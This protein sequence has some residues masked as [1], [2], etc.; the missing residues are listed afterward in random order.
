MTNSVWLHTIYRDVSQFTGSERSLDL[1]LT[2][3]NSEFIRREVW[4]CS[5]FKGRVYSTHFSWIAL[6]VYVTSKVTNSWVTNEQKPKQLET[7]SPLH[8]WPITAW[9]GCECRIDKDTNCS[10]MFT[11]ELMLT[12]SWHCHNCI[13][14]KCT[15]WGLFVCLWRVILYGLHKWNRWT[16]FLICLCFTYVAHML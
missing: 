7:F 10:F 13:N 3:I 11:N 9:S 2:L 1:F 5:Y 12:L 14:W 8:R 6:V 15:Y 16:R 4:S